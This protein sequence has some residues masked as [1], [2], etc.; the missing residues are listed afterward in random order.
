MSGHKHILRKDELGRNV[1]M[2]C[3]EIVVTAITDFSDDRLHG[4]G[5]DPRPRDY[6]SDEFEGPLPPLPV[7]LIT[8][9]YDGPE[10]GYAQAPIAPY[11]EMVAIH[12][13][14]KEGADLENLWV[15]LSEY[16]P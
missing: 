7:V 13:D 6:Q 2:T 8:L 16:R 10:Y 5:Y 14:R 3:R 11:I 4:A 9:Y 15:E 12:E 1:C